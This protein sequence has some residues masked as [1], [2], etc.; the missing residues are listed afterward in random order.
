MLLQPLRDIDRSAIAIQVRE[1]NVG[2]VARQLVGP[3]Q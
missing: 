1:G 3:E 2:R